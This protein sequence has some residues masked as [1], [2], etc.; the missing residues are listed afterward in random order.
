MTAAPVLTA[1]RTMPVQPGAVLALFAAIAVL[2]PVLTQRGMVVALALA[3]LAAFALHVRAGRPV[4]PVLSASPP[5]R[6]ALVFVLWAAL[7]ALWALVPGV[8]AAQAA[9]LAGGLLCLALLLAVAAGLDVVERRLVGMGVIAG[10]ILGCVL[11]AI[12]G[13]FGMPVQHLIRAADKLPPHML[14]KGLVTVVLLSWPAALH[15]WQLG[16]RACAALL[17]SI[18]SLVVF[19]Q[20]S[21]TAAFALGSGI[22]A[23]VL[24]RLLGRSALW[25]GALAL[26]AGTAA[27]PLVLPDMREWFWAHLDHNAWW[28]SHHRLYIWTFVL[29]RMAEKP[30]LGWGL[31][32][33]R[34]MPNFGWQGWPGYDQIIPLHPHNN[35]LQAWMELGAVGVTLLLVV[36]LV[37]L[38]LALRLS[39]GQRIFVAGA[40][41]STVA[42]AVPGYGGGQSWW[43]FTVLAQGV[44]FRAVL[45]PE[46]DS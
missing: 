40:W 24:A 10:V 21:L 28:S 23:A 30:W 8:A 37:P 34:A 32:A 42:A 20:D 44:L 39:W 4:W 33:S 13:F 12:D 1:R 38:R 5:L 45:I 18:V 27:M 31:E 9:Q 3:G 35:I 41:A 16:R 14:N 43:L 25:L 26:V 15:L 7:S 22:L 6:A 29:E 11:L 17:L 46:E 19:P 36:M 2:V